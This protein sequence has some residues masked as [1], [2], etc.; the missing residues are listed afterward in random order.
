MGINL[1]TFEIDDSGAA[2]II[3]ESHPR[4]RHLELLPKGPD[5]YHLESVLLLKHPIVPVQD[6]TSVVD[7]TVSFSILDCSHISAYETSCNFP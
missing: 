3:S 4:V 6:T 5:F 1:I 7:I 2:N